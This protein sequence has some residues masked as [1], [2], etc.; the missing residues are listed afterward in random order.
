[1]RYNF[2][3]VYSSEKK[4]VRPVSRKAELSPESEE[5]GPENRVLQYSSSLHAF[6]DCLCITV[7]D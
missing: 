2:V 7:Q 5:N 6:H 3:C 4:Y 1:M